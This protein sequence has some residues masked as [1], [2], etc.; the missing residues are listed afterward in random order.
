MDGRTYVKNSKGELNGNWIDLSELPRWGKN[1][2]PKEGSVNWEESVGNYVEFKYLDTEGLFKIVG[3]DIKKSMVSIKYKDKDIFKIK[4]ANIQRC[5]LGRILGVRTNEFKYKIGTNFKDDKRN[6]NIIEREYRKSKTT[7]V[8]L[9]WYKYNCLKCGWTEGW[10]QESNLKDGGGCA[11]CCNR[12]AVL[13]INTIYDTNPEMIKLGVSE[14]DAK[15]YTRGSEKMIFVI[16]PYCSKSKNISINNICTRKSIS[17]SCGDGFSYPEKF[18]YTMLNQANLNFTT[19]LNKATF[20]WCNN[21][22][23][24]FYF[25]YNNE[26]YIIETHGD[27]HYRDGKGIYKKTLQ[28]EQQNDKNKYELAIKNGIKPENYIVIDCRESDLEFIKNNILNS[29]LSE[30][31]DLSKIDWLRC[32]EF[33]LKNLVKEVCDYWNNKEEWETT[34]DLEKLF[35]IG[36]TTTIRYL[37]HGIIHGWCK[38]NGKYEA[39]KA[40]SKNG[41]SSCKKVEVFLNGESKGIFDSCAEL[42]RKSLEIFKT[43]L[44]GDNISSVCRNKRKSHKGYIFK[45]I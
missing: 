21:Y 6:L 26:K 25:E 5:Q 27:Q 8:N 14:E 12:T 37:K 20:T 17:C 38:Y 15:K 44:C 22:R 36:K 30:L 41:K 32:E 3:Y 2:K 23:Y 10:I 9:K 18:T 28:E 7:T 40:G 4:N 1:Q 33:A 13:G 16:C 42:E 39:G 34:K 11:C 35:K 45:Y 29:R 31:F 43:K 24:D 19:Q